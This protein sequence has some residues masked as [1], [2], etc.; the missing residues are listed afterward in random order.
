M[1]IVIS[2][3]IA[4]VVSLGIAIFFHENDK[5]KNAMDR[6]KRYA[7]SRIQDMEKS[8]KTLE[9]HFNMLIAEFDTRQNQANAAV[10]LLTQQNQDFS[11]KISNLDKDIKAVQNI[12]AQIENYSKLLNEL[13]EMT[14]QVEENLLRIQKE[15]AIVNKLNDRLYKQQQT[16]ENID[17]RIP[18]ISQHFSDDNAEQLK[19]IGTTLLD[20]YKNYAEKISSDISISNTKFLRQA[21]TNT[22]SPTT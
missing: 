11:D 4:S 8:Y 15:S 2:I 16:V 6:V 14:A 17:K 9:D 5:K 18:Q 12:E 20:E 19:A 22:S 1:D 10:K 13:N 21:N 7:D 3:L